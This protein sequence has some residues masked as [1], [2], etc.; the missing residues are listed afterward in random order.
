MKSEIQEGW[1][2]YFWEWQGLGQGTKSQKIAGFLNF[3]GDQ[4]YGWMVLVKSGLIRIKSGDFGFEEET[5]G[6]WR[7]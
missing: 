1:K 6:R 5:K 7:W 4:G 2:K 3:G